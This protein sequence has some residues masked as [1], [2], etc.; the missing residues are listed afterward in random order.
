[1]PAEAE[2]GWWHF[3]GLM[4]PRR[5]DEEVSA[6]QRSFAETGSSQDL[7]RLVAL[8]KAQNRLNAGLVDWEDAQDDDD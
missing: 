1:M 3:F 8:R 6:A 5:L 4:N 2:T 7:Q